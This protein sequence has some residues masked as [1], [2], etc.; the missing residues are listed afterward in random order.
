MKPVTLPDL[1]RGLVADPGRPRVTWYGPGGERVELS[2]K[3]LLNWVSK[4]ANL[5]VAELDAEPGTT[6][7]LDLPAHWRT[8]SWVLATWAAGAHAVVAPEQPGLDVLVTTEPG[9]GAA[10]AR[11]TSSPSRCRRSRRRS[12]PR[13]RPASSTAPSRCACSPTR[14]SALPPPDAGDPAL[15][16]AGRTTAHGELLAPGARPGHGGR[17]A[18]RRPGAHR[19]VTGPGA[20]RLAR[21]AGA[22]RLAGA[23]PRRGRH[24]PEPPARVD[25]VAGQEGVT[26]RL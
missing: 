9:A 13:C 26:R 12:A 7:G 5:L 17:R 4:T 2:G 1:L 16:A 10:A 14:S 24:A 20:H 8:V 6:V 15:T 25:A 21:R 3:T 19:R 11:S 18:P 22:R 23:A